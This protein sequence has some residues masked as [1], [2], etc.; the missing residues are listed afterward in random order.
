LLSTVAFA[1]GNHPEL[2][3]SDKFALLSGKG[4][5]GPMY[6]A[7]IKDQLPIKAEDEILH[8]LRTSKSQMSEKQ[9]EDFVAQLKA[10]KDPKTQ[11]LLASHVH[12]Y[13]SEAE[14]PAKRG[15]FARIWE[16]AASLENLNSLERKAFQ[17]IS[18]KAPH[19][20]EPFRRK[21]ALSM[22]DA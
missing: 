12:L 22:K 19:M 18:E 9:M 11:E 3:C 10:V 6:R 17:E 2:V 4:S 5:W 13:A 14:L 21:I 1:H 7:I 8:Y 16:E 20:P 15:A